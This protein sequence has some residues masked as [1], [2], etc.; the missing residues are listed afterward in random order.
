MW[1]TTTIY[2]APLFEVRSCVN[3]VPSMSDPRGHPRSLAGQLSARRLERSS[4]RLEELPSVRKASPVASTQGD[5]IAPGVLA[6]AVFDEAL[7]SIIITFLSPLDIARLGSASKEAQSSCAAA[8]WANW[9]SKQTDFSLPM[10][11]TPVLGPANGWTWEGLY[12]CTNIEFDLWREN[13][14]IEFWVASDQLETSTVRGRAQVAK[15]DALATVLRRH[16]RMRIRV[17]GHAARDAPT[18]YGGPVSQ[19]RATRIRSELLKRLAGHPAWSREAPLEGRGPPEMDDKDIE[20]TYQMYSPQG[21]IGSKLQ[22]RGVWRKEESY[23]VTLPSCGGQSAE[24]KIVGLDVAHGRG[25]AIGLS[26]M[27]YAN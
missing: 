3:A 2:L 15:L 9:W 16:P 5:S 6:D 24:V 17:E 22:A 14:V 13:S 8:Q 21:R 23:F 25:D 7:F 18:I 11:L 1:T 4:R 20:D 27:P 10:H 12:L 26:E 19:A